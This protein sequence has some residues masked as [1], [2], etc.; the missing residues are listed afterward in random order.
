MLT[1]T[2]MRTRR[3]PNS[4]ARRQ[5]L[6]Q[7]G[8]EVSLVCSRDARSLTAR[9]GHKVHSHP[10]TLIRSSQKRNMAWSDVG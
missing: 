7:N 3:R 5:G 2:A 9:R 10:L 4:G 1:I 6:G 8:E